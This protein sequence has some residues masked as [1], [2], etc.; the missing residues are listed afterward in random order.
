MENVLY[1][2]EYF[3]LNEDDSESDYDCLCNFETWYNSL[4][5]AEK[6]KILPNTDL[7]QLDEKVKYHIEEYFNYNFERFA[8]VRPI[9]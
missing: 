4:T 2:F 1:I 7:D 8:K 5:D 3:A 6:M 9:Q